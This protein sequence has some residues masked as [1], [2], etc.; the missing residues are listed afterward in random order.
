M[1]DFYKMANALN[2]KY[3]NYH[4]A[5]I[6]KVVACEKVYYYKK[7]VISARRFSL[8]DSAP[9]LADFVS[10]IPVSPAAVWMEDKHMFTP[11]TLLC[12]AMECVPAE[13]EELLVKYAQPM[14]DATCRMKKFGI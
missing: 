6:M 5:L 13:V 11:M 10:T 14:L 12:S 1:K 3:A 7:V 8:I 2:L 4:Q 9:N